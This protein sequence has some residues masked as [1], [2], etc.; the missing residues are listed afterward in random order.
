MN[1]PY[2]CEIEDLMLGKSYLLVVRWYEKQVKSSTQGSMPIFNS[3]LS[4][5]KNR[6]GVWIDW[7]MG[8]CTRNSTQYSVIIYMGKDSE[9]ECVYMYNWNHCYTEEII[10]TL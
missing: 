8:T 7:P 4:S 9:E 5:L 2:D 3:L 6:S 1:G 10:T